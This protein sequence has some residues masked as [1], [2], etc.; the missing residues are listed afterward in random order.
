MLQK[1]GDHIAECKVRA[2]EC[3]ALAR[4]AQDETARA[5]YLEMAKHWSRLAASYE[6]NESLER[7]LK[8][9]HNKGWPSPLE[10][11]PHPTFNED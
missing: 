10:K 11:L 1:L 4:D 9:M 7:F 5:Q 2:A 3:E 6:F 8:D